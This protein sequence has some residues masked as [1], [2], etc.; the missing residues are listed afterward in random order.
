MRIGARLDLGFPADPAYR[1]LFGERDALAFL[2]EFGI[3]AVETPLGPDADLGPRE[4]WRRTARGP[5]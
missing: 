3:E 2:R 5:A 1:E 4:H